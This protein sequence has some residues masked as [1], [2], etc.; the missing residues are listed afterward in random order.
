MDIASIGAEINLPY[1]LDFYLYQSSFWN[2]WSTSQ[3]VVIFFIGS[4]H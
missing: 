1:F 4:P 2:D 3:V